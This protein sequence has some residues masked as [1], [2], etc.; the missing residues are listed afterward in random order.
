MNLKSAAALVNCLA[1]VK[2]T[3]LADGEYQT[4]LDL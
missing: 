3:N 4:K 2:K 1:I